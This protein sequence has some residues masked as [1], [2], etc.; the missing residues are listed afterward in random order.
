AEK[1]SSQLAQEG[2]PKDLKRLVRPGPV[3]AQQAAPLVPSP[4]VLLV[5]DVLL[6]DDDGSDED[7]QPLSAL[8]ADK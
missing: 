2:S 6:L 4:V 1:L 7:E 8:L 3:P 5:D